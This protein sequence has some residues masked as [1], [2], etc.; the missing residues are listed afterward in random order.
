MSVV[1]SEFAVA[2]ADIIYHRKRNVCIIL[3]A[4]V[5]TETVPVTIAI[6]IAHCDAY[7]DMII[8]GDN[9]R[10]IFG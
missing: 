5:A 9:F 10:Y 2:I 8:Q 6:T 1:P 7:S 3:R 4:V